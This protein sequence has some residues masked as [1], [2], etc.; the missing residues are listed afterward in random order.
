VQT[1]NTAEKSVAEY[2]CQRATLLQHHN[3]KFTVCMTA[4]TCASEDFLDFALYKCSH[5]ITLHYITYGVVCM[6]LHFAIFINISLQTTTR[7][8]MLSTGGKGGYF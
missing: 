5:Y 8:Q 2:A 4:H 3:K 6:I 1:S 7:A